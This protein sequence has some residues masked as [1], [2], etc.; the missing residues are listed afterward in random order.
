MLGL[1]GATLCFNTYY[2]SLSQKLC[3]DFDPWSKSSS[4]SKLLFRSG[5]GKYFYLF[6]PRDVV[7]YTADIGHFDD[8]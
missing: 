6:P 2:F 8:V 1:S 7:P 4:K 3:V 5:R